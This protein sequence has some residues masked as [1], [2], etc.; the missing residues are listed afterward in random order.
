MKIST[1]INDNGTVTAK[2]GKKQRTAPLDFSRDERDNHRH[3]M[4]RLANVVGVNTFPR[5]ETVEV[6]KGRATFVLG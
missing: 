2:G 1:T 5:T 6:D 3:A 4:I